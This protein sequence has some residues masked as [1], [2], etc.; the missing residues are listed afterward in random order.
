MTDHLEKG[1]PA[2]ALAIVLILVALIVLGIGAMNGGDY[3]SAAMAGVLLLGFGC[4]A[5][6]SLAKD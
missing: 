5:F 2:G 6:L 3:A 1:H 4:Y